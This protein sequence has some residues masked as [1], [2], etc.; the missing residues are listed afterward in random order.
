MNA[1]IKIISSFLSVVLCTGVGF[2]AHAGVLFSDLSLGSKDALLFTVKND[3]PGTKNMRVY[4]LQN[5]EKTLL[6]IHQ[7][8]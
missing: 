1:R 6:L 4:S 3:I 2:K 8:F 7:K 5:L